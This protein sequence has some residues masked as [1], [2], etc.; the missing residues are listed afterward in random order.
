MMDVREAINK[1]PKTVA[2]IATAVLAAV[3]IVVV[4]QFR[5]VQASPQGQADPERAFFTTDDGKTWFIGDV[6][7][8]PPFEHEG[9]QAVR[10]YVVE[11]NGKRFVNHL[12]RYTPEGK[13]AMIKLKEA[14]KHGPPP[15]A[16]VAAAQQ[17]G[18]EVK[19][20]GET[21]WVPASEIAAAEAIIHS[22]PPDGSSGEPKIIYP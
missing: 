16:L 11:Y 12:E 1:R 17:R 14:V 5:D 2:A 4:L 8:L 9:K 21:K 15:G 10:A 6:T 7:Q 18:R 22:K 13:Q 19:R 20:P 3:L